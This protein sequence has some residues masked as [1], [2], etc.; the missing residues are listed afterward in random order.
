MQTRPVVYCLIPRD[1]APRLH[2]QLRRHF[3]RDESVQVVAE[4][5]DGERRRRTDRR[6]VTGSTPAAQRR[7]VRAASGR[8]VAER[9]AALIE[10]QAP[11]ALPRR[12]RAYAERL[13]FVERLEP[14]GLD[15]ED[16]DTARLVAG[17]Q[18][19]DR[20]AFALL[21]M[22][23]FDRVYR[24]LRVVVGD[25]HR[26]EDATQRVF[27]KV[28]D[29]LPRFEPGPVPFRGW[30]FAIARNVGLNEL[31]DRP[32]EE[33]LDLDSPQRERLAAA[34]ESPG[35]GAL[36]WITDQELYLFIERLPL[37]QRQVLFLRYLVQLRTGEIAEILGVS[38]E[39]VR[40]HQARALRFLRA[41]LTAI[42]R[43]PSRAPLAGIRG[44]ERRVRVVRARR[45]ALATRPPLA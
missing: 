20:D 35:L 6:A 31:R 43:G 38:P 45:Y 14:R 26:A 21:Y 17:I 2:E 24:Y 3:A 4:R 23:Y 34:E 11:A 22:R 33:S 42:G 12:V 9:R 15:S 44:L 13:V 41:R 28:L 40:Q 29:A 5:R 8:R 1:L 32:A 37:A 16:A 19:G 36:D 25:A 10:I 39:A 27:M 7:R 18:A 30:L